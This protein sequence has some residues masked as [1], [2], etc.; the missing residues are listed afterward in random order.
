MRIS[1]MKLAFFFVLGLSLT[2]CVAKKKYVSLRAELEAANKDLGK[3]G[4]N[5]NAAM[6]KLSTCETDRDKLR[7]DLGS[8]QS[9]LRLRE[10][11]IQDLRAQIDDF[12]TQRDKQLTQVGDL[13]VLS[14]SANDN[15][16][17]TLAQLEKKD[18][19]IHLL[20]A[21]K[22]K[23]DSI[24]LALA[25]NLKGALKEGI[26]DKDV[27][28]KVD[29]TVVFI[30][31]SDKML[32]QSGSA[33]LTPKANEVLG[34]IAKIIESRPDLEVMV[35]GYTDNKPIKTNCIEDNW[36]LSVKRSTSVVRA[37]QSKFNVNPNRLIAAGRGEYNTLASNDT[38][39]GRASNRRTRIII[40]PKIDQ[41][42][43][44][45]NPNNVPNK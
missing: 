4:E 25:V 41:F 1:A 7:T 2:S 3:C 10:E 35:E 44:L 33:S 8:S 9:A 36:D 45:L 20:Q 40:L 34:K 31:L 32:Y 37:L 6:N 23:A 43:D 18:K 29:K 26:D 12:K 15:I 17:E 30:N 39:A 19:Y 24:N 38:E 42:Y 5:L 28:V 27:D 11:Q 16:R 21:A 13:T 14:K 22:T